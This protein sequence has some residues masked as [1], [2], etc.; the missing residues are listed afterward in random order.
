MTELLY[1]K[2]AREKIKAGVDTVADAVKVTLGAKGR[3]VVIG[4]EPGSIPHLTKDGVTVANHIRQLADP[5]EDIGCQIIKEAS[6]RTMANV[7]DGTT[8]ATVLAQAMIAE[9][10]MRL[11]EGGNPMELKKGMQTALSVALKCLDEQKVDIKGDKDK[12]TQ[13]ATLSANGDEALGLLIADLMLEIGED[14]YVTIEEAKST[15]TTV[16]ILE[17]VQFDRGYINNAFVTNTRQMKVEFANPLILI[18]DKK[19]SLLMDI[20]KLLET[21]YETGRPLLIIAEDVEGEVLHTLIQNR[22]QKNYPFACVRAPIGGPDM[23]DDIAAAVNTQVISEA[24]GR[25]LN[26]VTIEQLGTAERV[27]VER[28]NTTIIGGAGG[29]EKVQERV[30]QMKES[31]NGAGAFEV[32][33]TSRRLAKLSSSYAIVSVGGLTEVEIKEKKDRVDDALRATKAAIVEGIVPGGGVAYHNVRSSEAFKELKAEGRGEGDGIDIVSKALMA[34]MTQIFLNAGLPVEDTIEQF[35]KYALNSDWGFNVKSMEW[36]R[37][38]ASGVIDPVKVS[39]VALEH[40]V[41]T[42]YMLLTTEAAIVEVLL[43]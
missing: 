37:F 19:L 4:K 15:E 35:E 27:V 6:R 39:K 28:Y 18:F 38:L 43:K 34:P 41:A 8:T 32:A 16:K 30:E 33:H 22:T 29:K 1:G 10:F 11:D 23:L 36:E 14:G 31:L 2:E 24:S 20:R 42:A 3:N 13:I 40:A 5:Y 12:L 7:G 21:V 25:K 17:G 26:N 9:G